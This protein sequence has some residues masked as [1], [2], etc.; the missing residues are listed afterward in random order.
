MER[1]FEI[2]TRMNDILFVFLFFLMQEKEEQGCFFYG[3][4]Q[5]SGYLKF[6]VLSV[7]DQRFLKN[8]FFNCASQVKNLEQAYFVAIAH[9]RSLLYQY[10]QEYGRRREFKMLS[11]FYTKPAFLVVNVLC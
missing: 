4:S 6:L 8:L 10:R 11:I 9:S 7:P 1:W 2:S 5:I 3:K